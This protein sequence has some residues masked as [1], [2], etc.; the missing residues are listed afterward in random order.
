MFD[1]I[2]LLYKSYISGT[3]QTKMRTLHGQLC[4]VTKS[5]VVGKHR[6]GAGNIYHLLINGK[7]A[8]YEVNMVNAGSV[9]FIYGQH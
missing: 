7:H 5:T 6:P 8:G 4:K 9:N 2:T 3:N 1:I